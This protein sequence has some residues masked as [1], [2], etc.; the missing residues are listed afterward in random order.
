MLEYPA[1]LLL[2]VMENESM[3][4]CKNT[5]CNSAFLY[6]RSLLYF[7]MTSSLSDLIY[8]YFLVFLSNSTPWRIEIIIVLVLLKNT[9][10]SLTRSRHKYLIRLSVQAKLGIQTHSHAKFISCLLQRTNLTQTS[11]VL[12][13]RRSVCW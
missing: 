6:F 1:W 9:T 11:N 7:F 3:Y 10:D 8:I 13:I 5:I 2:T 12:F 4:M